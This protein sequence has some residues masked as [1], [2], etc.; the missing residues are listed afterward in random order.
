[1]R[2]LG[3]FA[4]NKRTAF[5]RALKSGVAY[6]VRVIYSRK[7]TLEEKQ[8]LTIKRVEPQQSSPN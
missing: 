3:T 5:K 1:M 6:I 4:Y 2:L 8:Y 7:R